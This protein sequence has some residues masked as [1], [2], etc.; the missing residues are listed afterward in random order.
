VVMNPPFHDALG[1]H[2]PGLGSAFIRK[3]AAILQPGGRLIMVANR[4]LPYEAELGKAF[5]T[6]ERIAESKGFKVLLARK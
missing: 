6:V 2:A 3:A 1:N 4:Q 5:K